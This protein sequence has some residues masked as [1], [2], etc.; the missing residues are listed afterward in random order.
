MDGPK[1]RPSPADSTPGGCL[2]AWPSG[3]DEAC[4]A[5]S[6]PDGCSGSPTGGHFKPAMA[7][8]IHVKTP[9][10]AR[11]LLTGRCY[12]ARFRQIW[13][14]WRPRRQAQTGADRRRQAQTALRRQSIQIWIQGVP[15]AYSNSTPE[16][17]QPTSITKVQSPQRTHKVLLKVTS[18]K[19]E[20]TWGAI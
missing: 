18:T 13:V 11:A 16:Y 19:Q 3:G 4:Q 9:Q 10:A 12:G 6:P 15:I 20:Y 5:S 1:E 8:R 14:V 7:C 2:A 17:T